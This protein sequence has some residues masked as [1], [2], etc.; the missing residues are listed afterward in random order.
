MLWDNWG[1]Y[2]SWCSAM[3]NLFPLENLVMPSSP[4]LAFSVERVLTTS[5]TSHLD[6]FLIYKT[7]N[8]LTQ[9]HWR[10][11]QNTYTFPFH[12]APTILTHL[13]L[14]RQIFIYLDMKSLSSYRKTL[15]ISTHH[16][17]DPITQIIYKFFKSWSVTSLERA[18][19]ESKGCSSKCHFQG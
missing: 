4:A 14:W 17:N 6:S 12:N 9:L 11:H 5:I 8:M 10:H 16:S 19:S 15:K 3:E 7:H 18:V 2:L 1:L 13:L